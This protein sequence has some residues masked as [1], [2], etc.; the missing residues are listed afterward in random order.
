MIY[1]I[2]K[3]GGIAILCIIIILFILSSLNLTKLKYIKLVKEGFERNKGKQMHIITED[4]I[5]DL[6]SLVQNYL[7]YVGVVGKEKIYNYALTMHGQFK[8]NEHQAFSPTVIEQTSFSN[9]LSRLFYMNLTYKKLKIVGLHHMIDEK[10]YMKIKV[11][12]LLS[13]VNASGDVMNQSELVTVLNDMVLFAPGTLID[14]R[15]TWKTVS[16]H[17]VIVTLTNHSYTVSASLIFN[18]KH[19]LINFI[20]YDRYISLSQSFKKI[21][22][23]TPIHCYQNMNGYHLPKSGSAIWLF[24]DH[25]FEY[26][27]IDIDHINYNIGMV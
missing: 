10:A 12:D 6:P 15:I 27:K 25:D 13:V 18:D 7:R 17:E 22:W 23:S 3:Y 8:M 20:S 9:D 19:Q 11:L 26:M 16:D 14:D 2:L 4:D 5:K 24:D 21:P 1:T